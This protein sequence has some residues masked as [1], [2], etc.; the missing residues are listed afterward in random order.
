MAEVGGTKQQDERRLAELGYK[1][2][3][4][5]GWTRFTNFAISFSIISVLAGCFTTFYVG[6]NNGGPIGISMGWPGIAVIILALAGSM[7]QL[8]SAF[9][10]AGGPC[11]WGPKLGGAGGG[12][13][14]GWVYGLRRVGV[15]A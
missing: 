10:P 12:W 3:L 15:G 8:P 11:W 6:W 1:Q 5:R 13:V 4:D 9:P 2:E 14:S 7:F